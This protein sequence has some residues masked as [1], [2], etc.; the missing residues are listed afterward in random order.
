MAV[1]PDENIEVERG[2]GATEFS[3]VIRH[4]KDEKV[5]REVD[6]KWRISNQVD[7]VV[8]KIEFVNGRASTAPEINIIMNFHGKCTKKLDHF[9]CLTTTRTDLVFRTD[10]FKTGFEIP[11]LLLEPVVNGDVEKNAKNEGKEGKDRNYDGLEKI[12]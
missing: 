10:M 6:E 3:N 4:W 2:D 8:R 1:N 7:R 12:Y 11:V 9:T 5:E